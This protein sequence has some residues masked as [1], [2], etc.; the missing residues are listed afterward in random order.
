MEL[1]ETGSL[2]VMVDAGG[3][4]EALREHAP[5][6][7]VVQASKVGRVEQGSGFVVDRAGTAQAE[8]GDAL[9]GREMDGELADLMRDAI[10]KA[11]GSEAG[12]G[13]DA[14]AHGDGVPRADEPDLD[15]G[16]TQIDADD[17]VPGHRGLGDPESAA[18]SSLSCGAEGESPAAG[19]RSRTVVPLP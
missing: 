8:G 19:M 16:A 17:P 18:A 11:L 3:N 7:G 5:E 15:L 2:G 6:W 1:A 13:G 12:M 10:D 9:A 14:D 4:A